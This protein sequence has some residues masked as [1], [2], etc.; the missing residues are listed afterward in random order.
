[1]KGG[2]L[3]CLWGVHGPQPFGGF[4]LVLG[5]KDLGFLGFRVLGFRL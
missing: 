5:F 2:G 3:S 4:G 1:M